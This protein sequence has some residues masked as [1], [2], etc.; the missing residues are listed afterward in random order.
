MEKDGPPAGKK[1]K[2]NNKDSHMWQ[3]TA[4]FFS[5]ALSLSSFTKLL[6]RPK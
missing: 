2:E 1:Y 6:P 4:K 5:L 3:V